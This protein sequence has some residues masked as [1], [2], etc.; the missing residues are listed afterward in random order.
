[1]KLNNVDLD[2]LKEFEEKGRKYK[3]ELK[4]TMKIDGEW[5]LDN[6]KGIQFI[7]EVS[8]EKGKQIIKIDSP[9]WLGGNGNRPG[10][11]VYCLVGLASCFLSTYATIAST[12]EIKL[13]RLKI[14]SSCKINFSKTL[15]ISDDPITEEVNFEIDAEAENADKEKLK[16]ILEIA[17]QRCPAIYSLT[18]VIKV[19][20]KLV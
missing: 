19:N 5:V 15:G 12:Q 17:K 4:K 18:N 6:N 9:S 16:E 8:F 13:K 20:A 1:M 3:E 14:K 2:R 11:M 10:P 7:S